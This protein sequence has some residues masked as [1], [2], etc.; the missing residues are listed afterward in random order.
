M[1]LRPYQTDLVDRCARAYLAHRAVVMQMATGGGKTRCAATIIQRAL[2]RGRRVV[3]AAHLDAIIGDTIRRLAD[4]GITAGAVQAGRAADP[5]AP[6]QV[7]SLQT[8]HSRGEAPPADLVILDECHRAVAP[9]VTAILQRYPKAKLLGLTATPERGDG[10]PLGDVFSHM[11]CGPSVRELQALGVLVPCQVYAPKKYVAE[12]IA[13]EPI[14]AIRKHA[15][16]R[17][18]VVFCAS[19]EASRLLAEQAA[20][21]GLAAAHVSGEEDMQQRRETLAAFAE[22]R[23]Q[24]LTNCMVLTEG[25]DAPCA[26]VCILARG[27]TADSTYLQMVGRVLRSS[28]G[29][30]YAT[31]VDL[32]G[33]IHRHG[34]PDE[35]REYSLTRG[36]HT[37]RGKRLALRSCPMCGRTFETASECVCGHVFPKKP[38][39]KVRATEVELVA[40][41][42]PRKVWRRFE[43]LRR[44]ARERQY[45]P[46]WVG[47]QF[48][49]EFG[50]WPRW[51]AVEKGRYG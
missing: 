16:G 27:C 23:V 26:E 38:P 48:K 47:I 4:D 29:K 44:I 14:D 32:K 1:T 35:P 34:M 5:T 41:A 45:K 12:G 6:V 13:S 21:D 49:T 9:T 15:S 7:C 2:A 43:E 22:K 31:L 46:T 10:Q 28:P 17:Q 40:A 24:V 33:A 39:P 42:D 19:V 30:T 36:I 20:A 51:S 25:W 11:E 18:T 37:T 50:F 3:F 8:L